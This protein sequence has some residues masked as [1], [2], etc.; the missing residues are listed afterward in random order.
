MKDSRVQYFAEN[1]DRLS[2]RDRVFLNNP[3]IMQGLG[4]APIVLP[5]ITV[6][7]ALILAAAVALLLTPTR[8][9]ATFLGRLSKGRFRAL[10]YVLTA[11]VLYI[12]VSILLESWFGQTLRNVGIYL[13][14]LV[15]EPLIIKRY[16]SAQSER[17]STS[18]RKGNI[19]TIGFCLVL[20]I[21]AT[22]REVLAYG[23]FAGFEVFKTGML[24]LMAY[25]AG[26]FIMLGIL[27]AF[28]R[29]M[30]FNFKKRVSMGVKEL[31]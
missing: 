26:G 28:W 5:A 3:V 8:M 4:L 16:E 12:G 19:T 20:F 29:S 22:L 31:Q 13:P 24:P 2:R 11:S 7:N 18:F 30:V 21:V 23:T 6:Q 1:M 27:A 25:P 14:L 9:I 10:I 15:F 17:I